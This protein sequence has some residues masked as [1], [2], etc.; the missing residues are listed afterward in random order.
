MQW[1]GTCLNIK[2]IFPGIDSL[3]EEKTVVGPS[4]IVYLE[5][6]YPGTIASLYLSG[7]RVH[8]TQMASS[9]RSFDNTLNTLS[10]RQNGRLFADDIF[11]S[12]SLNENVW[13]SINI[14]FHWSLYQ[15]VWFTIFQ[16]WFSNWL[17]TDQ[18]T[19]HYLD[20]WCLVY[21]RMYASFGL[22][23][24]IPMSWLTTLSLCTSRLEGIVS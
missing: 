9:I 14:Q 19:S 13:I 1:P 7:P 22:N 6:Q 5:D 8:D 16:H 4:Y 2:T 11:A 15:I 10:P 12:I 24:L 21:W 23:E 20:Q 18:A 17:G 3:E